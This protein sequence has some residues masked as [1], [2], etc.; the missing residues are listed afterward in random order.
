VLSD[1]IAR[2]VISADVQG[3]DTG[4]RRFWYTANMDHDLCD[5][6]ERLSKDAAL[7]AGFVFVEKRRVEIDNLADEIASSLQTPN[8]RRSLKENSEGRHV[9]EKRKEARID[10]QGSTAVQHHGR[11]DDELHGAADYFSDPRYRKARPTVSPK[12]FTGQWLLVKQ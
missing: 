2:E 7:D 12:S 10:A 4:V 6:A 1:G 8:R 3:K 5:T 11:A 9:R